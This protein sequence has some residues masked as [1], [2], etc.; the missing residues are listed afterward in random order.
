MPDFWN[1]GLE[2]SKSGLFQ[3]LDY[4]VKTKIYI[5]GK[6]FNPFWGTQSSAQ[7]I[8]IND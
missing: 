8:C 4:I 7:I 6:T 5:F 1:Q 3:T 2:K